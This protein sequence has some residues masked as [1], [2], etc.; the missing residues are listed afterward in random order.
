MPKPK[1]KT[2]EDEQIEKFVE[3]LAAEDIVIMD[4]EVWTNIIMRDTMK[5]EDQKFIDATNAILEGSTKDD[6]D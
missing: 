4:P 3:H 1:I 6:I 2:R 5:E